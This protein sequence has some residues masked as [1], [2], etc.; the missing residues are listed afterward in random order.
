M[1]LNYKRTFLVGFA[2]LSICA[3]WQMYDAV[4]PLI[5]TGTFK[6]NESMKC[7]TVDYDEYISKKLRDSSGQ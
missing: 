6:L 3:F 7:G 4:V 5:L 1:K 2:F